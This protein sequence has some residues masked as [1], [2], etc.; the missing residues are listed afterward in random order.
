MNPFAY[1]ER[2][3]RRMRR[4][5]RS[6]LQGAKFL[7]GGTNLVD[8]MKY[9]VEQPTTLVD[10]N[11]VWISTEIEAMLTDGV[12][13]GALV[14]NSD[15]ANHPLIVRGL[16]AAV[17]GAADG[18]VAAVAQHGDDRRESAAAD[19]LLLLYGYGVSGL[20]QARAGSRVRGD[21]GIQPHPR[22]PGADG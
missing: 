14:R 6:R 4:S 8:L 10:I 16:S 19:A 9:D 5:V 12:R 18:G 2:R 13:I 7:G 22:D 21:Q 20:Q 11:H 1:Q 17:A 15:L 3:V